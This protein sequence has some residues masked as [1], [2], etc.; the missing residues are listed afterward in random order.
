MEALPKSTQKKR[1][2]KIGYPKQKFTLEY[3]EFSVNKFVHPRLST[4]AKILA[5]NSMK[6]GCH[7]RFVA[8]KSYMNHSLCFLIYENTKHLNAQGKYY[9]GL[10]VSG[11]DTHMGSNYP[12]NPSLYFMLAR[13]Y[14]QK[15]PHVIQ[16]WL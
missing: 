7:R 5:G 6:R 11:F 9:Y 3:N 16:I 12:R 15:N 10:V 1:K 13:I 8:K 4:L 2:K 14:L